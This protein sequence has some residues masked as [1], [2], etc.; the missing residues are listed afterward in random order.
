M[1]A[2][3]S[4]FALFLALILTVRKLL[5][6]NLKTNGKEGVIAETHHG[7]KIIAKRIKAL[8]KKKKEEDRKE[9]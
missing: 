6:E 2:R 9:S 7:F 1:D 3:I 8:K 4:L 5:L